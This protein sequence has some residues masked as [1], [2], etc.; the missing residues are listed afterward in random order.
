MNTVKLIFPHQLFAQNPLFDLSGT[1]YLVEEWLFFQQF[2]FHQQKLAFHRATMKYY[3]DYLV[4]KGYKVIYIPTTDEQS[5]VRQLLPFLHS[6]GA[7]EVAVVDPVDDWLNRRLQKGCTK[8]QLSLTVLESPMFLNN[9][10]QINDFFLPNKIYFRQADFYKKE[11]IARK[12]LLKDSGS[13]VGGKWSFDLENRKK[14]PK[15]KP[16]AQVVFPTVGL[17]HQE[18][19]VY[20]NEHFSQNIGTLSD[21]IVY[22]IGFQEG[23]D[24]LNQFLTKRLAEFGD[25][26]DA[27]VQKESL[28]NHS[29]LTPL[30][31]VGMITPSQIMERTLGFAASGTIPLNSLEGFIRQIMGWREFIRGVYVAK[32]GEERTKN[33][34]GFTRKIPPSFYNGTTGIVPVDETIKKVLKTGYCHH[35]ERLM[36][37]GNFFLL[38]E[39][40]PNEVYRWFMEL[41]IDAY[42]WVMVP[43]VYGMSQFADGGMMSSKPY[44]SGSNYIMKMSDYPKGD[45]QEIWDALF[46]NFL[47]NNRFYFLAN[48]RIG[49]LVQIYDKWEESKKEAVLKTAKEFLK[50]LSKG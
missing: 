32:G 19:L 38:C 6:E 21:A 37:L 13:P 8:L 26:E 1:I 29:L 24:W 2:N 36:V 27:I 45:W 14:Y 48:L 28:L 23:E 50:K 33:F 11:R 43:N 10:T 20:V 16:I 40:D 39:F 46:W 9:R 15:D 18:A 22:P 42:D 4:L 30:L 35:I 25:Y 31:N 44:I 47:N 34:W 41:F 17:Y 12:V 3:Y 5:D 49:M 7:T